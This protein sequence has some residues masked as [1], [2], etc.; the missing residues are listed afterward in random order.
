L[1][2][3][4]TT[5]PSANDGITTLIQSIVISATDTDSSTGSD[6]MDIGI[7][8]DIPAPPAYDL[9]LEPAVVN[10]NLLITFDI[11]GSMDDPS[12]V[13]G[14]TRIEL[15]KIA[16]MEMVYQYDEL[17]DVKIQAVLF[18]SS[19]SYA[20]QWMTVSE[21]EAYLNTV[22][23]GG[24][25]NYDAALAGATAAF[26]TSGKLTTDAQNIAYFFSDGEPTSGNASIG[27]DASEETTWETFLISN[28]IKSYAIG[29]GTGVSATAL[30]PIAYDGISNLE[31]PALVVDDLSVLSSTLAATV[32]PPTQYLDLS[33]GIANNYFGAD[34]GY[35]SVVTFD[36]GT[37]TYDGV[38]TLTVSGDTA[39]YS[40]NGTTHVLTQTTNNGGTLTLDMDDGAFSYTQPSYNPTIYIDHFDYS[41]TDNDGDTVSN[42]AD[43]TVNP[44]PVIA[45]V[46]L[47]GTSGAN[48]LVG[49]GG[50]DTISGLG[51][52]DILSGGAGNDTID[53]GT[54]DDNLLG[55]AGNDTL[56]GGTGA[57]YLFGDTGDDILNTDVLSDNDNTGSLDGGEGFDTL[58]FT[59]GLNVDLDDLDNG[60]LLNIEAIDLTV[61]GNHNF[62]DIKWDDVVGITDSDKDLYIL[63]DAL[64]NVGFTSGNGW[65]Q[66]AGTTDIV[67]NGGATHTFYTWTNSNDAGI[68]VY[69]ES[70]I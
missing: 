50:N 13:A 60:V 58:T 6:N 51:G 19:A 5:T 48:I 30:E 20:T 44:T 57:D 32:P 11:S 65:T 10:T 8:D 27:I 59:A 69:V 3:P 62:T 39:G 16:V 68:A 42:I 41:M 67:V 49:K 66:S 22:S 35:L 15:A 37:Y 53:G 17:G 63:G 33:G 47:V 38:N 2:S 25:T 4:E 21:A 29:L 64:D 24:S 23:A 34:G 31:I 36:G 43:I 56:I 12:G 54:G 55:G 18:S 9:T 61:N 26:G 40:F 70:V 28:Y 1:T 7:V 52:N 46:T 14:L 45:P